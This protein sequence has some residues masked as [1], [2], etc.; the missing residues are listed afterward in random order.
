M[1]EREDQQARRILFNGSQSE[2]SRKSGIPRRTLYNKRAQPGKITL[3]ELSA[4]VYVQGI[5]KT[6]LWELVSGRALGW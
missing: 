6:E 1:L 3:D 5:T 2:L 4:L